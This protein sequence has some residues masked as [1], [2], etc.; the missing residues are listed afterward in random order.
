[1]STGTKPPAPQNKTAEEFSFERWRHQ[2]V[3]VNAGGFTY[4]G[5]LLG[6]DETDLYLKGTLRYLVLPLERITAV[7]PEGE[8]DSFN[9]RKAVDRAF[10]EK[11]ES[12]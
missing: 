4:R 6:A 12:E 1:V 11:P 10:Y 2:R 5:V 8:R 3:V 7:R 9:P